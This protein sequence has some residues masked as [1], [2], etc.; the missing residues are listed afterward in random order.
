M[1]KT[2]YF[3]KPV[4]IAGFI[5]IALCLVTAAVYTGRGWLRQSVVPFYADAVYMHEIHT[6]FQ[7]DFLPINTTL[8]GFGYH[9]TQNDING[10]SDPS[11][12][13][14][15][16]SVGCIQSRT[17]NKL[18]P[19]SQLIKEWQ[20]GANS[21]ERQLFTAGWAKDDV[22]Q[23]IATLLDDTDI[24]DTSQPAVG[25]SRH[26]GKIECGFTIRNSPSSR[27]TYATEDCQRS[28][29]FFGGY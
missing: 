6:H 19:N 20:Q 15:G 23:P 11:F 7:K 12:G 18:R 8:A 29:D 26:H 13:G 24:N 5:L 16:E 22:Q 27:E 21:L 2:S 17:S 10:C 3:P 28:V 25:Y 14:F 9:F 4:I 1:K